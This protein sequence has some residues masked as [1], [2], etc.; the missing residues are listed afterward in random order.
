MQSV[1][2]TITKLI[3]S[4]NYFCKRFF[5]IILAALVILMSGKVIRLW[6]FC[7]LL[8]VSRGNFRENRGEIAGSIF[9][10]SRNSTPNMTGRRFHRPTEAIPRRPWKS[11]SPFASR[12]MKINTKKG[13][14]EGCARG[15]TRYFLHSFASYSLPVVQSQWSPRNASTSK[16]WW[17]FRPRK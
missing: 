4:K 11:T 17:A 1:F 6:L 5:V 14:R 10:E 9:P 8:R 15:M 2:V 3:A 12:P 16:T 7:D 13:G